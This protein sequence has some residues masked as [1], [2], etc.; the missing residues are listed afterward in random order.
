MNA[1]PKFTPKTFIDF[2]KLGYRVLPIIPPDAPISPRSS[3]FKRVETKQDGR[4]KTPGVKGSDGKWHSFDWTKHEADERDCDRWQKMGAGIGI[5]TG[6]GLIAVD[7]DTLDKI[8]ASNILMTGAKHFNALLPTR[9]GNWP[10]AIYLIRVSAPMSYTRVDFGDSERV[11]CLSDGRQFV[12]LGTHP[13]TLKPYVWTTPIVPFDQLPVFSPSQV[14]AFLEELRSILPAAKPLITE[15]ATT[16]IAQ[17]SLRGSLEAVR[18]AVQATPNTTEAFPTR[19][20]Y[21]DYGYAIKAALPDNEPE[22][23]EIFSEWSARWIENGA[24]ADPGNDPDVVAADW[25]RMK[26][27]YRRGASWLF[28]LAEQHNPAEFQK[29]DV[30]FDVIPDDPVSPRACD[31]EPSLYTFPDPAS[32][33]R[34]EWVYGDHYIRNFV[35]ATV[36]PGGLGKSSLTIVEALAMAS[37]QPLLGIIPRGRFRVWLWNGEDPRDELDRRIG[38]AMRH[39]GL[40]AG[41]LGDRLLVDSGMD[42]EIVLAREARDGAAIA[43]PVAGALISALQ[44]KQIDVFVVDPFVSSHRVSEN[45]NGAIDLVVKRWGK[46]AHCTRTSIELVHHVRKTNGA[47]VTIEDARGASALVNG[48]RATRALTRMSDN[49]GKSLGVTEPWRYFRSGGV[50]KSNLAPPAGAPAGKAEWFTST[51]VQLGNGPGRGVEA[52]MTGDAVGV[53]TRASLTTM[54]VV[55]DHDALQKAL[56]LIRKGHWRA[57]V[58]AGDNWVGHAVAQAFG[59]D[60]SD[61]GDKPEIKRM[62]KQ[63]RHDRLIDDEQRQD[64]SRHQRLFVRVIAKAKGVGLTTQDHGIFA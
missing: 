7:A 37:G 53:V 61:A 14:L 16:D 20:A 4:G 46:I 51:S 5:M 29:A 35:S 17:A 3:L 2:F 45:D 54:T 26:G 15:G 62:L 52:L 49:E 41:D 1:S 44:G 11:E 25:R 31:L 21:R 13:K 59:L 50:A 64:S 18:K 19:E 39:Y 47:E 58:R 63:W 8:L 40:T 27:P 33:P 48:T 38:A 22:A 6:N 24:P 42:Q 12:A 34:R 36:A 9:V 56:E 32:I 57:D 43:E 30:W 55:Q 60:A 10:K 23:F 28:E